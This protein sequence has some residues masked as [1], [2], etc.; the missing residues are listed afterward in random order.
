MSPDAGNKVADWNGAQAVGGVHSD[1]P[2]SCQGER[3][4]VF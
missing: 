4:D 2:G 3:V 1:N